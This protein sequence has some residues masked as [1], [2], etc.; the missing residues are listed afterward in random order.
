M[1]F[2]F[3]FIGRG[4][5]MSGVEFT[6]A[7]VQLEARLG[8]VNYNLAKT[9]NLIDDA[10]RRG[11]DLVIV[12]EFF[13]TGIAFHPSLLNAA[14]PLEGRA[15]QLLCDK[16]RRYNLPVGGSFIAIKQDRERY[17]TFV[18]AFPDGSYYSHDKDLP[19]M[20]ENC[21][22]RGGSDPGILETP[23]GPWGVA[24]C[25]ELIR[26]QTARRLRS[27]IDLLVGG[28]CW[29]TLPEKIPLPLKKKLIRINRELMEEAPAR[30]ARI[31]GV[32]FVHAA[33]AGSFE[34]HTPWLPGL[35]YRSYYLG[36]TQIV[37]GRGKILA[38]RKQS[39][40]E[41]IVTAKIKPGRVEPSE[42]APERF[43]I[44]DLHPMFKLF[45]S[46][47]NL[48]GRRYYRK[49]TRKHTIR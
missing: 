14:L 35:T 15:L 39:E 12:P 27:K 40:G 4:D 31:L 26:T 23:L 2:Y 10:F 33:H 28:S 46:Y 21:Y 20:W 9:N 24:L 29:W 18:L 43:W 38:R 49:V 36:E 8:D 47:Q 45:W 37:D 42:T 19:T 3:I 25:W 30:M 13:T 48:H 41:G 17:N 34:C 11:A 6:A 7:A 44:P 32:P 5:S 16:A 1:N 22:Y